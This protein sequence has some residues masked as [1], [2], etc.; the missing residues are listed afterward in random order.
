MSG[1]HIHTAF[2]LIAYITA[3]L[4][5]RRYP[6]GTHGGKAVDN[7]TFGSYVNAESHTEG[8]AVAGRSFDHE[9]ALALP[10]RRPQLVSPCGPQA[11]SG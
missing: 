8:A 9:L 1:T 2:A 11:R 3:L 5:L 6:V 4:P 10:V 7:V